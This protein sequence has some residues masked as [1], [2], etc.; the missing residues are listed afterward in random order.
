MSEEKKKITELTAKQTAQMEKYRD[1]WIL[2]GHD[3]SR[4]DRAKVEKL[5]APLYEVAK[6]EPPQTILW[7]RSPYEAIDILTN[8]YDVSAQTCF[9]SFC[10]G[11]HDAS[12][13]GFYE[14]FNDVVNLKE[15][16]SPILPF[17]AISKEV[18]WFLPFAEVICFCERP[19]E[20]NL[21]TEADNKT[22]CF[23]NEKPSYVV[24]NAQTHKDG[25]MAIK[26]EDGTG[27]YRLHGVEVPKEIAVTPWNKLD[28]TL[29]LSTQNAE[30]RREIVRKIGIER[31][32]QHLDAEVIDKDIK[33]EYELLLLDLKDGRKRPYLK[34]NNPS[35]GVYHIEGVA[36]EI[37]SIKEALK[38]RN[39]TDETPVVLT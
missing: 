10:Y 33:G 4:C 13:L 24:L 6:L 11:Q 29:I 26:F 34:M 28:P 1:K 18:G 3:T 31:I 2:I 7:A 19:I 9:N 38:F 12:W 20:I 25:D 17:I 39:G 22:H 16:C 15:D 5:V 27:I 8:K 14:Y 32:F 30:V 23:H 35:I 21:F 36:P 37:T